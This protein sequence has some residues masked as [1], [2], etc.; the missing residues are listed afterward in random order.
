ME[1]KGCN[2]R[3]ARNLVDRAVTLLP[4]INQLWYK[5][6]YV[7]QLLGNV[8]DARQLFEHWMQ[9]EH[10]W[11]ARR[12]SQWRRISK[13]NRAGI[14]CERGTVVRPGPRAWERVMLD[15]AR[16]VLQT[17]LGCARVPNAL[18]AGA[19]CACVR[20][21]EADSGACVVACCVRHALDG[22]AR[23]RAELGRG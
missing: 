14:I 10:A 6:V 18:P 23:R 11:Q 13:S 4:R 19:L 17:V 5:Y 12:I 16:E 8:P 7:E 1:I 20:V 15:K 9:W 21:Q 2:V 3:H 22:A